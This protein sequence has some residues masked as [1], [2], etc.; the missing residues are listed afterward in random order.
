MS[1]K[2]TEISEL[3]EFA[4]IDHLNESIK[5]KNASTLK[6]IGDDAAV[7]DSGETV[8]V[9]TTDLLLEGVHFDLSY[10]P[11]H[12]VGFKAVAV[13]VSDVAAM[14]AIPK[15]I[16][17]SI[18]LSNRFSVEAVDA[19]YAGINA[20]AE[21]YGVDVI[22]GDTTASHSG[23]V[24]SITAIGEAKKEQISYRSGAKVNDIVCVT[25]DL[26]AALVGLQ[27]L[28]REK[29]VFIANPDMKPQLEN[30]TYVTGRQLKP[31]ARMDI[32]HE[33]RDLEIVPSSMIDIS[34]GLASEL[35]HICKSS[36][37]GV[38]I[39]EDKLPIDKQTFDTA[40][41]LGLDP[42][43]CVL[44]GGEDYELLFTIDQKDYEKLEK[45][46]D[47]HFIGHVTNA[48]EG[49]YL[50]TK[51]GTTAQLKAQGWKHF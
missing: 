25:G 8:K 29:Q 31:D 3:G 1:E 26:G 49:K 10:A 28:E 47:I 6:G 48:E 51:S 2:R 16:T 38:T 5:I 15:Q 41:E 32:I 13:N 39:Y 9:V 27:I 36:G 30:F 37:V 46:P 24:I 17:V 43:T 22:G 35:F 19:L 44:N 12:H 18:A 45:H 50:V 21:H 40:V 34:D 11:L 33:M 42:I 7:I 23:L 14:N 4:L 20:A